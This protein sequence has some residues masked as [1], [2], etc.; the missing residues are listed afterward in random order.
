MDKQQ[1]ISGIL[2]AFARAVSEVLSETG[3]EDIHLDWSLTSSPQSDA[4]TWTW[5]SAGLST[6]P[7]ASFFIGAPEETWEKL[8]R[9]DGPKNARENGSALVS[10]CFAKAVEEQF[11]G[12]AVAQDS[13]PRQM[14]PSVDWT[15]ISIEIQLSSPGS[16]RQLRCVLGP[17]FE[18]ARAERRK[19]NLPPR[20]SPLQPDECSRAICSCTFRYPCRFPSGPPKSA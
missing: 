7:G 1:L 3:P 20:R 4:E 8:G 15:R 11:G 12:R 18:E 16:G 14:P 5:W 2:D 10:R 9:A 6:H 19:W 17:E 13:W